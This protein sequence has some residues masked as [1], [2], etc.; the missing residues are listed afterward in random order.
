MQLEDLHEQQLGNLR[1]SLEAVDADPVVC[2]TAYS[3]LACTQ[4]RAGPGG[5]LTTKTGGNTRSRGSN[6]G[7]SQIR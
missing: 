7:S 3:M 4:S 2:C 6:I 5:G 1:R